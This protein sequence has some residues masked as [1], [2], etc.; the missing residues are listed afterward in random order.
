MSTIQSEQDT[1]VTALDRACQELAA[2]SDHIGRLQH[3]IPNAIS[4][5]SLDLYRELQALDY[6]HQHLDGLRVYLDAVAAMS[7]KKWTIDI[8][9]A[10]MELRLGM[11]VE[12]LRGTAI[13]TSDPH[14]DA[15][16]LQLLSCNGR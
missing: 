10:T 13:A 6:V 16:E 15:G 4:E 5:M 9:H 11:M 14:Q 12:R 2:M 3:T 7:D 1:L 8:T